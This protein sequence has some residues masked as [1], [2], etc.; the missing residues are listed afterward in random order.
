MENGSRGTR[1]DSL[2]EGSHTE[3]TPSGTLRYES[4]NQNLSYVS[5]AFLPVEAQGPTPDGTVRRRKVHLPPEITGAPM[6]RQDVVDTLARVKRMSGFES[7]DYD[8]L[9]SDLQLEKDLHRDHHDYV[10]AEF[11]KWFLCILIGLTM[12]FIAFLVDFGIQTLNNW[13]YSA[14]QQVI[15]SSNQGFWPPF[16]VYILFTIIY[17]VMAGSLVS[18]VEPL[19]AGSGIPE[20]KT[21]LNGIHIKGLLAMKTIAAK[22]VGILFSISA[23]L[24]AGKEGPFVHGGGIVGGGFGGMGSRTI[25]KLLK[26]KKTFKLPRKWGGYF[27]NDADHRDF[28]AIGTAA[29]VAVAFAAPIGGLLFTIEEGASFYSTSVF[30]R[31]F[32]ATCMGVATLHYLVELKDA[33]TSIYKAKLGVHR[34]FGLYNDVLANYGSIYY[35]FVWELPIFVVMGCLGGLLGALFVQVNVKVTQWRHKMIPVRCPWKRLGEV[36]FMAVLT[37]IIFFFTSYFSPCAPKPPT[38]ILSEIDVGDITE[39][40]DQQFFQGGG[41][42][43]EHFPQLWCP[44]DHYSIYGQLFFVPLA[45]SLR[46][47]IHMGE[48]LLGN[49]LS[50]YFHEGPLIVF[51][52][53]CYIMMVWTYGVGAATGL[54]VPSLSVGASF[55]RLIG[56][57]MRAIM[58]GIGSDIQI[59]LSSYAII[60]AAASLG[61]ATRM[62]L[63]ITV[64]IMETTGSLELIVPIM[65]TVFVAKLVGDRFGYG[66]YDTHIKIRGSPLLDEY[67]LDP[68]Q[69]MIADKIKVSEVASQQVIVLPPVVKVSMLVDT[70]MKSSHG[71]FAVTPNIQYQPGEVPVA[72][73]FELHGVIPRTQLLKMIQHRIGFFNGK[74]LGEYPNPKFFIPDNQ[75]DRLKLLDELEQIPIKIRSKEDQDGILAGLREKELEECYI[76]LRPFMQKHPYVIH[77]DASLS[78]AYRIF[79]TMG[80]R[81]LFVIPKTPQVAG[82]ITRKDVTEENAK[83]I[84]GLKANQ[85]SVDLADEKL[86]SRSSLPFLPYTPYDEDSKPLKVIDEADAFKEVDRNEDLQLPNGQDKNYEMVS[87][88]DQDIGQSDSHV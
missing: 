63:S 66:I 23:G 81:H 11:W 53:V 44:K 78:R 5:G 20:L 7:H 21:Y 26:D 75:E 32:L 62:T 83:L 67:H 42:A 60:G 1:R 84:L 69:K 14:T 4:L 70:L 2:S 61:G 6:S 71:A 12:G 58:L 68:H 17:S 28:T 16:M 22:L 47:I 33:D 41:A 38:E 80:L 64:L 87:L 15:D 37:A 73:D 82:I 45:Q 50:W 13:K 57:L 9:D 43:A 52:V 77:A 25:T 40:S 54:F 72:H 3:R 49:S 34:D 29:G 36:V 10:T 39:V 55:G 79:R 30:W 86:L 27:R 74:D 59:S 8:P 24:I 56:R 48:N 18:F 76:D 88:V 35:Y 85:G 31:G 19:A 51:F 65:I 46:L